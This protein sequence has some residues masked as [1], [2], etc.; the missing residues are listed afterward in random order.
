MESSPYMLSKS[1]QQE[2]GGFAFRKER[3]GGL[4]LRRNLLRLYKRG[5]P[6]KPF[7]S[8]KVCSQR[9]KSQRGKKQKKRILRKNVRSQRG[10]GGTG[11]QQR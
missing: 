3:G 9:G 11:E 10:E 4:H 7:G 2:T 1:R 6:K 8:M 5:K